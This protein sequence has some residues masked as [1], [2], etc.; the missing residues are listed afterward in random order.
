MGLFSKKKGGTED[1]NNMTE[2]SH[3][4]EF[5]EFPSLTE[6]EFPEFPTYEPTVSDIKEEV[7]KGSDDFEVPVRDSK[8]IDIKP[9][10]NLP[11]SGKPLFVQIDKYK[12]V[13]HTMDAIKAK[14]DDVDKLL[15]NLDQIKTEEDRKL[16]DWKRD[17]QNIK[18][19][20]VSVDRDLFEV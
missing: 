3:V 18:E 9:E 13:M 8:K 1:S 11:E 20:L 5:P 10:R 4:P 16:E 6:E 7:D 19:K 14:L 15:D 12:D 17:L 2:A